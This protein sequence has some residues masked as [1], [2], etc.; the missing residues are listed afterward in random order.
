M[1]GGGSGKNSIVGFAS[2]NATI[3]ESE[4]WDGGWNVTN[5]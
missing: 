4:F 2:S 3:N 1:S 5:S